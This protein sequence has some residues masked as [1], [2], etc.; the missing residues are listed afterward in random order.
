MGVIF[1]EYS[2]LMVLQQ[3]IGSY[4]PSHKNFEYLF[5]HVKSDFGIEKDQ[6][7]K[8]AQSLHHDHVPATEIGMEPGVWV[9][10]KGGEMG[11][12]ST[13]LKERARYGWKVATLGE[14]AD[15]V[16][17]AFAKA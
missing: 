12:V 3:D 16:E 17:E 8:V 4:K 1:N 7:L 6:I 2:I 11:A 15:Q 10:R 5:D 9:A 14:L 13:E